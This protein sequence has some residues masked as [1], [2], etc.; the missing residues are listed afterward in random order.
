VGKAAQQ[1]LTSSPFGSTQAHT[2][3]PAATM[4]TLHPETPSASNTPEA[5]KCNARIDNASQKSDAL[6]CSSHK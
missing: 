4:L 5:G 6:E 1:Q 2:H 3:S